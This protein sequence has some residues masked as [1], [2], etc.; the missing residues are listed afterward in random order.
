MDQILDQILDQIW[1]FLEH[2]GISL[3]TNTLETG[4]INNFLLLLV[5]IFGGYGVIGKPALDK[6]KDQIEQNIQDAEMRLSQANDRLAQ[7]SKQYNQ[8]YLLFASIK[9]ENSINLIEVL[10][11]DSSQCKK[12]IIER[13]EEALVRSKS[14]ERQV[15]LEVK[16]QTIS[17][18]LSKLATTLYNYHQMIDN[19]YAKPTDYFYYINTINKLKEYEGSRIGN[20]LSKETVPAVY[21]RALLYF[22]KNKPWNIR[23]HITQDILDLQDLVAKSPELIEYFNIP[24]LSQKA[25]HEVL[26][27]ILKRE[28]SPE[29]FDFLT[30]LVNRNRINI[31]PAIM[32]TYL[33][34][35]DDAASV[36]KVEIITAKY[37]TPKLE[38]RFISIF[39]K[40]M[41]AEQLDLTYNY[42]PSLIAGFIVK[43]ESNIIDLSIKGELQQYA[44]HFDTVLEI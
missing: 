4:I 38:E 34:L 30:L 42:D 3:N 6:R 11:P 21:A 44:R 43:V 5:L 40:V 13:F 31:L 37:F 29:T 16:Q 9:K 28:V 17:C 26:A 22:Q 7:I 35:L 32:S 8:L 20:F 18:L 2:E 27:K 23:I 10:E 25:K 24:R 1:R 12:D 41:K 33:T 15:F 19:K 36:K 39:R 14:K